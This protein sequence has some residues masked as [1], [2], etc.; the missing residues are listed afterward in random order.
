LEKESE[1][2]FSSGPGVMSTLARFALAFARLVIQLGWEF[3]NGAGF[4]GESGLVRADSIQ[5]DLLGLQRFDGLLPGDRM[6]PSS[7]MLNVDATDLLRV[8]RWIER[9]L[10]SLAGL[11]VVVV[12]SSG[13]SSIVLLALPN[14]SLAVNAELCVG[15]SFGVSRVAIVDS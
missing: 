5:L 8:C 11:A 14:T 3:F 13:S 15:K 2:F 7:F 4:V 6:T 12:V 1:R 10:E 9:A